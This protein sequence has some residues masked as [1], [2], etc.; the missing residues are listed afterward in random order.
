MPVYE[1]DCPEC[2]KF[3]HAQQGFKEIGDDACPRCGHPDTFRISMSQ[4]LKGGNANGCQGWE[5]HLPGPD[6]HYDSAKELDRKAAENTGG[7]VQIS[8]T[9]RRGGA[10]RNTS[11][12]NPPS[13]KQVH[14]R[15]MAGGH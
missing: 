11:S 8:Q 7:L 10:F 2:G 3:D 4:K 15:C 6:F 13:E 12:L 14:D 1:H 9:S 5:V